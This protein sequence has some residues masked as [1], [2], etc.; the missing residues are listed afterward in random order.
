MSAASSAQP[1]AFCFSSEYVE[2]RTPPAEPPASPMDTLSPSDPSIH[3]CHD[4]LRHEDCAVTLDRSEDEGKLTQCF[5]TQVLYSSITD[6]RLSSFGD[7]LWIKDV[8][9]CRTSDE[10]REK[11]KM[12]PSLWLWQ[13]LM[14]DGCHLTSATAENCCLPWQPWWNHTPMTLMLMICCVEKGHRGSL[15]RIESVSDWIQ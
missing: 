9:H 11:P 14:Y 6:L 12:C 7:R 3:F 2:T 1:P 5:F 13:Q 4:T 10:Q 15:S 8:I